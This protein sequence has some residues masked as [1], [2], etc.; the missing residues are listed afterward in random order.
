MAAQLGWGQAP[1]KGPLEAG[2][3]K[4]QLIDVTFAM[5][6][7]Q[8]RAGE[9]DLDFVIGPFLLRRRKIRAQ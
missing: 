4:L 6:Y 3:Y 7:L 5:P 2:R 1:Y 8:A 9:F